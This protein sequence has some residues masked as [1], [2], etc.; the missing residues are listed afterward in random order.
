VTSTHSLARDSG[1]SGSLSTSSSANV[2][3]EKSST[4]GSSTGSSASGSA[5]GMPVAS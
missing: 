4:S 1:V 3:G 5:T 2:R